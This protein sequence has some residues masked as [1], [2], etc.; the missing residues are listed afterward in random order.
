MRSPPA[1]DRLSQSLELAMGGNRDALVSLLARGSR[2]PGTRANDALADAFAQACRALGVRAD[3]VALGLARLSADEAPGASALEFLPVCGVMALG[4]RASVDKSV[5]KRFVGE[6]HARADDPRFRVRDAVVEGLA[7]VGA[8]AGDELVEGVASWMDGYF[9]AAA[10]LRALAEEAWLGK[11]EAAH[12]VIARLDEAFQL[13]LDAP[14]AAA[15]YPGHKALLEAL[16]RTPGIIALRFGV[17]VF[18]VML[19]WGGVKDP[20]LREVPAAVLGDPK[21]SS[22]FGADVERVRRA[23]DASRPPVRNP[24]HDFGPTRDRS[25]ARRGGRRS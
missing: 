8:G 18:D 12:P 23:L 19:R 21:L 5:R 22:R 24:D 11:L 15:R 6:L 17:P 16:H 9:H 13:A 20:V 3:A 2:L 25:G 14:R 1:T 10:V 7:R 4:A